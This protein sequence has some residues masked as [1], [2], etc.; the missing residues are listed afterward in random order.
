M[1]LLSRGLAAQG[2]DVVNLVAAESLQGSDS[3]IDG[4]R[5]VRASSLGMAFST[6]IAPALLLKAL[7]LNRE[8]KFDI[9]HV[10]LPD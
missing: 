7:A 5:L 2:V 8:K 4:Y 3:T 9:V 10:H 6:A 1:A